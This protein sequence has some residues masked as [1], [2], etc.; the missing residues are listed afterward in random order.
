[1]LNC[2]QAEH[3]ISICSPVFQAKRRKRGSKSCHKT[4]ILL[5]SFNFFAKTMDYPLWKIP[6]LS[7]ILTCFLTNLETRFFI[8][9]YGETHLFGLFCNC[10]KQQQKK[11]KEK[12]PP[13]HQDHGL[14]PLEK[15]QFFDYFNLYVVFKVL[16]GVF[17]F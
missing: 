4:L 9:E 16:I 11:K 14:I 17:S 7:T 1:M 15:S 13:F 3:S 2:H 6:N 8:L 5:K 12:L 10:L